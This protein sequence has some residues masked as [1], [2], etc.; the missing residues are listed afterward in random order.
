MIL[1][2]VDGGWQIIY[3]DPAWQFKVWD[4]DTGLEKSPD[5]H[6]Q[7]MTLDE[8][9]AMPVREIAANNAL[10]PMWVYDPMLP[11]AIELAQAWGFEFCTVLFRWLKATDGQLRLFDAGERLNFGTGY[12]TR[13]G[14]CEEC[15]LFKRGRGLPV[16]RHDIRK[17]FFA[18]IR[19][20]SRK[21][22]QVP[23]WLT[24]LYGGQRCVELFARTERPGWAAW[25]NQ[26]KRF[27]LDIPSFAAE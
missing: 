1:P 12:H 26:L 20:H 15:W 27:S 7:T 16:L 13:G 5:V 18:P 6:Y 19:E 11:Q 25:G 23:G 10:L 21:P 3:A 9:K 2:T 22:D 8:M 24:D 14:G 17:E 4:D